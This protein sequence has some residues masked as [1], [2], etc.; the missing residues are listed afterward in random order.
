MVTLTLS[1][2]YDQ[3]VSVDYATAND[4]ATAGSDYLATSGT[5]TFA[6]GQTAKQF[7]V[8]ILGDRV[9]EYE[10][11]DT[12]HVAI[13]LPNPSANAAVAPYVR[14]L[15]IQEDEPFL[16]MTPGV[17][18][19]EGNAGT[20]DA[21]FTVKLSAAY[22]QEV[23]VE[24]ATADGDDYYYPAAH[25]GSDYVPTSG[26]LRIPAGQTS[27]TV[28]VPVIGD[29]LDEIDEYFYLVLANP[30][31][32]AWLDYTSYGLGQILDDDEPAKTWVGPASDG[33]WS[34]AANWSPAGVPG[35]SDFVTISGK[36]VN[37]SASA[38]VAGLNLFGGATLTL[39]T[40]GDRV[41]R[42]GSL[43][44]SSNSKLNLNDNALILDYTGISPL[45]AVGSALQSGYAGGAWNGPGIN[46]S[47]A[48]SAG[49]TLGYGEA[50]MLYASF[51]ATFAGQTIDSTTILCRY[52]LAGDANL[53][54]KVDTIDFNQLAANFGQSGRTFAQANFNYDAAV[55]TLDFNFLASHFGQNLWPAAGAVS[56]AYPSIS[57]ELF[58]PVL[59]GGADREEL[60]E[61]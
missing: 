55:D 40:S 28:R 17:S 54:R 32:N 41:V 37:I 33:N 42:I 35:A 5:V 49:T 25:A 61:I 16:S 12:E 22:D 30:S 51:P 9:V 18:V 45:G 58:A 39:G 19:S 56:L 57:Q 52:T 21:V 48:S 4:S 36:S 26:T 53:D 47:S 20:T 2:A 13:T 3:P 38:T 29:T 23:T 44:I 43:S 6:P 34:T 46:S 15:D 14:G 27:R 1:N 60:L 24:Y 7:P 8:T 10:F 31:A 11:G 50:S 59:I